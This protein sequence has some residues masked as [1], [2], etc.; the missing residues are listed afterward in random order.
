MG[1]QSWFSLSEYFAIAV[2]SSPENAKFMILGL[3]FGFLSIAAIYACV[4]G[5]V[6]KLGYKADVVDI[7]PMS[8]LGM[9]NGV[10]ISLLIVRECQ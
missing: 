4:V 8:Y 10:I 6:K 7:G 3:L 9:I 1:F 2:S 5:T